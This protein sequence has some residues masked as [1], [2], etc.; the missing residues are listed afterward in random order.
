MAG[1]L[2]KQLQLDRFEKRGW[3]TKRGQ[4]R[5]SWK[6]RF[7]VLKDGGLFYYENETDLRPKGQMSLYGAAAVFVQYPK[8]AKANCLEISTPERT[9]YIYADSADDIK[10]WALAIQKA[11]IVA[12]G[13]KLREKP[14]VEEAPK[15]EDPATPLLAR[16]S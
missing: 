1:V 2:E 5:Q 7:F 12:S 8:V 13:G 11:A 4:I 6:R 15:V 3:L 14:P 9:L 16:G 10:E